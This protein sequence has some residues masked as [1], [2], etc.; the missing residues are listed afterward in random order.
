VKTRFQLV[1]I[2]GI[3]GLMFSLV[4]GQATAAPTALTL[5]VGT[6]PAQSSF[7]SALNDAD[8][9][10]DIGAADPKVG[11]AQDIAIRTVTVAVTDADAGDDTAGGSNDTITVTVSNTTRGTSFTLTLN[12]TATEGNFSGTFVVNTVANQDLTATPRRLGANDGDTIRVVAGSLVRQLTADARRPDIADLS[13]AHK[14]V[15]RSQ[16]ISFTGR[17]TD[18]R[19]AMPKTDSQ[20]FAGSIS[21]NVELTPA[22]GTFTD[23]VGTGTVTFTATTSG[24]AGFTFSS[25]IFLSEGVHRWNVT[26]RDIAGNVITSDADLGTTAQDHHTVEIDATPPTI[27]PAET[28]KSWDA[29][30]GTIKSNV[31][32]SI[33]VRL[34]KFVSGQGVDVEGTPEKL[35]PNSLQATDFLVGDPGAVPTAI[36]FP[37]L[38]PG[39]TGNNTGKN[40]DGT[41]NDALDVDLRTIVFLT[42]ASD[43]VGDA[44]PV[45]R[46]TS[47]ISDVAGNTV[48]SGSVTSQD[49]IGPKL[50]MT[51]TGTAASRPITSDKVTITVSADEDSNLPLANALQARRL[52]NGTVGTTNNALEAARTQSNYREVTADRRWEWEFTR[53][54]SNLGAGL[55][56]VFVTVS[57]KNNNPSTVGLSGD[58]VDRTSTSAMFFEVDTGIQAPT[59]RP[60]TTENPNAFITI[61]FAGEAKEYG[62]AG[63]CTAPATPHPACAGATDTNLYFTTTPS[64]VVTDFDTHNKVTLVS[65]KLDGNDIT[66]QVTF[67]DEASGTKFFYKGS[68][69]TVGEHKIEI[70]VKDEAGNIGTA[71]AT[72]ATTFSLVFNVT[73]RAATRIQFTPGVNLVSFPGRP[74]NP[75]INAVFPNNVAVTQV[76]AF[77]PTQPGLWVVATRSR[78]PDGTFGAFEGPLKTIDGARG[79]VVISESAQSIS[80]LV[81]RFGAGGVGGV[82][83][84]PPQIR[85]AAGWNFVPVIDTVGGQTTIKASSYFAGVA[86]DVRKVYFFDPG[87]ER[88]RLIDH[89]GAITPGDLTDDN[90]TVGAAYW[91]YMDKTGVLVP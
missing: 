25:L 5:S 19:S 91:V 36:V 78:Q 21:I 1:V 66:S 74:D 7:V 10:G 15:T 84:P 40:P 16:T 70:Q 14:T 20:P 69:L 46:I 87:E 75:D 50:T 13:P 58:P 4:V 11:D 67:A 56:N 68:N 57:D 80:T 32:N 23:Q 6:T 88:F 39:A 42:L 77:D 27:G 79:Y 60:T 51:I 59:I 43:L 85:L 83:T 24:D 37:N 33:M 61:D 48:S 8:N 76:F 89:T 45:V 35:D 12:E 26:A 71:G 18:A 63:Q 41:D 29:A 28:G 17:V 81:Q 72:T 62:L 2:L 38:A 52:Q 30:T 34:K 54:G 3:L 47:T 55:Y 22:S 9:D 31:R 86:A 53:S 65:A 73:E 64:Q 49:K 90:L 44:K 82:P